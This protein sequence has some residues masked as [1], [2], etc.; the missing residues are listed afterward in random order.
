MLALSLNENLRESVHQDL[1]EDLRDEI[2]DQA[3][4]HKMKLVKRNRRSE[5]L[6]V[7]EFDDLSEDEEGTESLRRH[8]RNPALQGPAN[9]SRDTDLFGLNNEDS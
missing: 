1:E 7:E 4:R 5:G 6:P 2:F 8:L 9:G 3:R